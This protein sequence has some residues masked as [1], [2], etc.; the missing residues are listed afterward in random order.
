MD[1]WTIYDH[2]RDQPDKFV[3]RKWQV[4]EEIVAGPKVVADSLDELR[5]L[6]LTNGMVCVT[7]HTTDDPKIVES[8]I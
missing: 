8:W 6:A 4:T 5:D 3:M 2:P 7:R 1:I